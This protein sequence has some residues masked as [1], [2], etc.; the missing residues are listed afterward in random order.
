MSCRS[1]S[2]LHGHEVPLQPSFPVIPNRQERRQMIDNPPNPNPN[3]SPNPNPNPKP[4]S[5]L[6]R[7]ANWGFDILSNATIFSGTRVVPP[8]RT[9]SVVFG[10]GWHFPDLFGRGRESRL[11]LGR[12]FRS[13]YVFWSVPLK[14]G[15][16]ILYPETP[17]GSPEYT[18]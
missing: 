9:F 8:V 4:A 15:V 17:S 5:R 12:K 14:R 16:R 13:K 6:A 3:P 18:R 11:K 2:T 7:A 10:S 1:A